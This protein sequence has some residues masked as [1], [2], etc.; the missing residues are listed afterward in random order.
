MKIED[1]FEIAEI[2]RKE[3]ANKI[4]VTETSLHYYIKGERKPSLDVA[5]KIVQETLGIVKLEDLAK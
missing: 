2:T 4:G 1:F 3:F 5:I